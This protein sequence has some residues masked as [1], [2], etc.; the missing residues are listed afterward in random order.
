MPVNVAFNASLAGAGASDYRVA[1]AVTRFLQQLSLQTG[2]PIGSK[3]Q[4]G[5]AGKLRVVVEQRRGESED[6]SLTVADGTARLSASSPLGAVRGLETLL[7]LVRQNQ[8]G[9]PAG[10]SIPE[11]TVHDQPRFAWR[12]LS[13]DVSRHFLAP[14]DMKRTLDLMGAVKLNV[15]HWH[16][17]D[18]QGFRV[19]SRKYPRLQRF[20]S[21]GMYYTQADIR[22][23][24]AYA[25][26]RG[27]RIVPEFDM[28][29][30]ATSWL[31][32]YPKLGARS[33]DFQ[34]V[35]EGGILEDLI[36][37]TQE[38]TYRFLDG[39][40]GEMASLFPDE[41]F[42][43]GGDEV[44]PKEWLSNPRIRQFMGKHHIANPA[45]LQAYFNERLLK[46]VTKH[47]KRMIGWDEVLRPQLPKSVVIQ[48][49]RGQNSLW[50]AAQQGHDVILSAGYYLDLMN[51]AWYHYAVDPMKAPP[52][53]PGEKP[54]VMPK[55]ELTPEIAHHILGG[56]AAMWEELA[57][58]E[59][60]DA[61]LWPRLAA[62]AERFWS[63]ENVTDRASMYRRLELVNGW[64]EWAGGT[65]KSNL[66]R[67]RQRLAG[68]KAPEQLDV[69]ASV[70]EPVKNYKRHMSEKPNIF[71]PF[72]RLV[73]A[74]PPESDEA[75]RFNEAVDTYL[76]G[77]RSETADLRRMLLRWW[78]NAA[79]VR[80]TL[81]RESLLREQL[82]VDDAVRAAC[83]AGLDALAIQEKRGTAPDPKW[84][85]TTQTAVGKMNSPG[86][87]ELVQITPGISKLIDAVPD[88]R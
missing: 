19:E 35:R 37:P 56:E 60:I 9:A 8:E 57:T 45:E 77:P 10:F 53:L 20:G 85:E 17:S 73:D 26:A 18:D 81:E 23:I 7:Q 33:G 52:A 69:F 67:M 70:L 61:K 87:A 1:G 49:W 40:I 15:L 86:A 58:A 63:P 44:A 75:R 2:I 42:H 80:P 68:G 78:E 51:P 47:H 16:L 25:R 62:I 14:A 30:H 66:Q 6:Y 39:F 43:I 76:S 64:L 13:L 88:S 5:A 55:I 12:G 41:Y 79:A 74:I 34:L 54:P 48:S 72:N 83:Q 82:P 36:D 24:V 31:V 29:G 27:I 65:Q 28:P 21:D 32:G 59:N 50:E 84:K 11:V 46:I 38:S 22:D 71:T 3:I 4:S